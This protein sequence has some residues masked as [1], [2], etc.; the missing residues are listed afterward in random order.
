MH[1]CEGKKAALAEIERTLERVDPEAVERMVQFLVDA[2]TVFIAGAG[3]RGGGDLHAFALTMH[4][5]LECGPPRRAAA[6]VS[7]ACLDPPVALTLAAAKKLVWPVI[8][9]SPPSLL[10]DDEES[11]TAL[12]ILRARFLA[13]LG[14]TAWGEHSL[15]GQHDGFHNEETGGARQA[16]Q[17]LYR[18]LRA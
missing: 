10:A 6:F 3:R 16:P 2:K 8:P 13:P 14:M 7:R 17:N 1:F 4:A 5:V 9:R 12:K 11:R 15:L 18:A